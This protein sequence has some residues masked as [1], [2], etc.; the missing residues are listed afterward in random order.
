[1][2]EWAVIAET[3]CRR[4]PF[5]AVRDDFRMRRGHL[6][7]AIEKTKDSGLIFPGRNVHIP[8]LLFG[9]THFQRLWRI[10]SSSHKKKKAW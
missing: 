1:M 10:L 6:R 3:I 9:E 5:A 4:E 2:G 8:V 7:L